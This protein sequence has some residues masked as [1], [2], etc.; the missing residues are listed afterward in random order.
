MAEKQLKGSPV[1]A[2]EIIPALE[3]LYVQNRNLRNG[4]AEQTV[5]GV[6][7]FL[8]TIRENLK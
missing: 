7:I 1:G 5:P 6:S 3:T 8:V 2:L 4:E